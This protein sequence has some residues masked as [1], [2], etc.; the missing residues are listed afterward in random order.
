MPSIN[1][2]NRSFYLSFLIACVLH[3]VLAYALMPIADSFRLPP[4]DAVVITV[5]DLPAA[6]TPV[7]NQIVEPS[8]LDTKI[9]EVP[10]NLVSERESRVA[11]QSI[12]R[13]QSGLGG[14][15]A[16]SSES[17]IQQV[18]QQ[19]KGSKVEKATLPAAPPMSQSR[20]HTGANI[21]PILKL[22]DDSFAEALKTS[23]NKQPSK[24]QASNEDGERKRKF[25]QGEPFRSSSLASLFKGGSGSS[26]YLPN[27]PDGDLTLLNAKADRFSVFVRRV[28]LQVF[29]A[30]RK[31]SWQELSHAE[32]RAIKE[33]AI[34]E[35]I[36]NKDGKLI[37]TTI[38]DRSGSVRFD[39]LLNTAANIGAW[40]KNPPPAAAAEDGYIHFI[41]EAKTWSRVAPNARGE[42]RWILLGTGLL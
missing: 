1:L 36:M 10:T 9:A 31:Q 2:N 28:A 16:E 11:K 22:S 33:F 39:Q 14:K 19:V 34:I 42:Q 8:A 37:R 29:G 40:D 3:L 21:S 38:T 13:G 25:Y 27:I 24:N 4:A 20:T 35:A 7:R 23:T 32:I 17:E 15:S 30:L 6:T 26:D 5:E 18:K 41:F 12:K